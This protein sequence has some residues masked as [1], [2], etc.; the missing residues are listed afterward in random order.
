MTADYE[1]LY[2]AAL[3][4]IARHL[5]EHDYAALTEQVEER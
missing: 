4:P 5:Q 1:R 3:D 2:Q